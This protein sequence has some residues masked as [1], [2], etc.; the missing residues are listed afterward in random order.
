[1]SFDY[2]IFRLVNGASGK[3]QL[4]D[5]LGLF[6]ADYLGYVIILGII[7]LLF[8]K[9]DWRQRFYFF[10]L[11]ALSVIL[12]RGVATEVI[13]FFYY[14]PRPFLTLNIQPLINSDQTGSFPSGHATAYFALAMVVY[15]FCEKNREIF[16]RKWE[17]LFMGAALLMGIARIFIGVHWPLDILAGAII[18]IGSAF[19]VKQI[20]PA[21]PSAEKIPSTKHQISNNIQ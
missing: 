2:S 21:P 5:W 8:L 4:L 20:L 9:K 16:S 12:S 7:I 3:L 6:L 15:Y 10:S 1:M 13:R 17:W 18:G 11:G 19:L 14:R